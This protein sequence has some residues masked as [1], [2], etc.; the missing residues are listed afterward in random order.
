MSTREGWDPGGSVTHEH[1]EVGEAGV[2]SWDCQSR[3]V[4]WV[5]L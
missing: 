3:W 4:A 5:S 1:Q 2:E